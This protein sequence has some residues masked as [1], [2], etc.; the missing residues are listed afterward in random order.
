M[1]TIINTRSVADTQGLA[2][3]ASTLYDVAIS[4]QDNPTAVAPGGVWGDEKGAQI[5]KD[6]GLF[7]KTF[8][9]SFFLVFVL[10]WFLL[11]EDGFKRCNLLVADEKPPWNQ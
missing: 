5:S 10:W 2:V 6:L 4:C 7:K 9:R 3:V 8:V 11:S 1:I